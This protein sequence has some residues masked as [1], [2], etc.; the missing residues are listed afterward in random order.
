M[1]LKIKT[2]FAF[3]FLAL[4]GYAQNNVAEEVAWVVGDEPIFKSEIEEQY[5]QLQYERTPLQG[6]PYCVIPE[7]IAIDKLF[8]H[9]A[10]IDSVEVS[11]SMVIQQAERRINY[12]INNLGSKEKVEEYFRK[13]LPELREQTINMVRD[14]A[15]IQEVQSKLTKDVKPT[16]A[17]VRKYFNSLPKDSLPYIPLQVEVKI[18]TLNPVIPQQEI[19]EVKARLRDY[20]NKVNNGESEFSTLAILYSEDGS[21]VYGGEIGFMG[22]TDLFPE[23]ANVA[24]NLNDTKKVS[25]IVETDA[26]FHIIQLIEKRGD[27][28][29]TRH[30]LLRPKVSDK[31]LTN[32]INQLDSIRGKIIDKKITFDEAAYYVSQDKDTKLNKGIMTNEK[33]MSSKFEMSELNPE[34]GKLVDKMEVGDIS[35]AFVMMNPK[36]NRET[37]AIVQLTRRIEGHKADLAEDYQ[38]VKGMYENSKKQQ[39]IADWIK[40]KQKNTYVRIEEGWRDCEFQYQW[41]K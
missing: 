29:N 6:N 10:K 4:C 27:R 16:P 15:T 38:T 30:I 40:N 9:Q 20:T 32:A 37:V 12:F 8:L 39:I 26:G 36:T 18:I 19:D 24:F 23:Y 7:R 1:I 28:V 35:K 13:P 31:D 17:D 41:G 11:E 34:I 33:T 25:K 21:S 14:Q 5:M 22:K 2:F 3:A